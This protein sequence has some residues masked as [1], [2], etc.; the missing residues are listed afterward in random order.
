[1]I[2][3]MA[4]VLLQTRARFVGCFSHCQTQLVLGGPYDL[5]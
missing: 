5:G 1:M 2:L 3:M 4:A